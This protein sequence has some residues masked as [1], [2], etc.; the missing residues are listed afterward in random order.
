MHHHTADPR[1]ISG[2]AHTAGTTNGLQPV[3]VSIVDYAIDLLQPEFNSRIDELVTTPLPEYQPPAV[4]L[5]EAGFTRADSVPWLSAPPG[6][7]PVSGGT[8][9]AR[10]VQPLTPVQ[11]IE[12]AWDPLQMR[13]RTAQPLEQPSQVPAGVHSALKWMHECPDFE[14]WALAQVRRWTTRGEQ[15]D[16][17]TTAWRAALDP[18]IRAV[19]PPNYNGPLHRE[20][21]EAAGYKGISVC[22]DI[23]HGFPMAGIMPDTNMFDTMASGYCPSQKDLDDALQHALHHRQETLLELLRSPRREP[24]T[25]EILRQTQEDVAAGKMEGPWE[26]YL[27]GD[28]GLVSTVPFTKWLP[29]QRF[30]RVQHRSATSYDVRPIDNCTASGLNPAA[31]TTEAMRVTGLSTLLATTQHVAEMFKDWG[32]DGEPFIAKGDHKKAYRQWAVRADHRPYVVT[33]VW[34]DNVG[35]NGGFAAYVHRAL[36]FGAFGAVWGYARVADSVCYPLQRLFAVPQ[37]AY[38]DDFLRAAPKRHAALLQCIFITVHKLLGIPLKEEKGQAPAQRM[39]ALGLEAATTA[40]WSA[41]RLT[42]KRRDDLF[43]AVKEALRLGRLAA[44]DASRLGGQLG[45]ASTALFGRVGRAYTRSITS[46]KGGW[47]DELDHSLRWWRALLTMPLHCYQEHDNGKPEASGWVDGSWDMDMGTGAL[48]GVLLTSQGG[49][50]ISMEI[51]PNLCAELQRQGKRQ[52]NTQSELLAIIMLLLSCPEQLRGHQLVLYEDNQSAL[53]NV[54]AGSAGD[55]DSR[56]LVAMV[57][58]LAAALRVSI[59]IDYVPSE[60]NPADCFSRPGEP[61][62]KAEMQQLTTLFGLRAVTP[63]LPASM[64]TDPETWAA[65]VAAARQ[66]GKW[67]ARAEQANLAARLNATDDGTICG[68]LNRITWDAQNGEITIGWLQ[69]RRR[70]VVAAA[71][72]HHSGL[73]QLLCRA[74]RQAYPGRRCTTAVLYRGKAPSWP[75]GATESVAVLHARLTT[76]PAACVWTTYNGVSTDLRPCDIMVGFFDIP[77]SGARARQESAALARIGFPLYAARA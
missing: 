35:P 72:H 49:W 3:G 25:E 31:A 44:R 36:P 74:L 32:T 23:E 63:R 22:D 69:L 77:M 39:P 64:G 70:G 1:D 12:N 27:D 33:L 2:Q 73:A 52:R 42:E 67:A 40:K 10:P 58:L 59:W 61:D 30:P 66:P 5:R 29:T 65:A 8:C 20:M 7:M 54:L 43:E 21:L 28:G 62:K 4:T 57:W 14:D 60:S 16:A 46:H 15:L 45:F 18:D 17:A 19:L 9:S 6:P 38:V 71:T 56:A 68:L 50:S 47:S 76:T 55:P 51:P 37:M 11:H 41:L 75:R 26:V 13:L 24:G 53:E 34:S 48:G